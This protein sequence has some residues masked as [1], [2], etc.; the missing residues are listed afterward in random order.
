MEVEEAIKMLRNCCTNMNNNLVFFRDEIEIVPSISR[1]S[2]QDRELFYQIS[3]FKKG[4]RN[5]IGYLVVELV[6]QY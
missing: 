2:R 1:A 4:T 6:H 5:K 3:N